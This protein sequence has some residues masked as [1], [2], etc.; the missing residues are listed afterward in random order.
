MSLAVRS[1][2]QQQQ[3]AKKNPDKR[4]ASQNRQRTQRGSRSQAPQRNSFTDPTNTDHDATSIGNDPSP[5]QFSTQNTSSHND[6][7][8]D[9]PAVTSH[10]SSTTNSRVASLENE[11][12]ALKA[13]VLALKALL[14]RHGIPASQVEAVTAMSRE[15]KPSGWACLRG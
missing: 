5:H 14:R 4:A 10:P 9:D 2:E 8:D 11:V 1:A 3:R 12:L 7:D 15:K 13:E 6:N